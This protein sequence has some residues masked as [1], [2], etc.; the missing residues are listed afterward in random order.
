MA[1]D[2]SDFDNKLLVS[3]PV[4]FI[5]GDPVEGNVP[6]LK[7]DV[8]LILSKYEYLRGRA[9]DAVGSRLVCPVMPLVVSDVCI[10][11]DS[12]SAKEVS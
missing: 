3:P 10:E 11:L 9:K 1:A 12:G 7:E 5:F 8:V 6:S 4:F 2:E